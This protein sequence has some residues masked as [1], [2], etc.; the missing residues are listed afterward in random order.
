MPLFWL[1]EEAVGDGFY[2]TWPGIYSTQEAARVAIEEDR[3]E[4]AR[5]ALYQTCDRRGPVRV[6]EEA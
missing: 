4:G 2:F 5:P 3:T 1:I 6:G